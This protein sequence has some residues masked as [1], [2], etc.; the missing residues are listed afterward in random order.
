[1]ETSITADTSK[2]RVRE[3][4]EVL[5]EEA[6][7]HKVIGAF[8]HVYNTLGYGFLEAVYA[9]ALEVELAHRGLHVAREIS[10]N[11]WYANEIV[12]QYR[13]DLLVE[14][15]VVVELKAHR[16]LVPQDR[17]QLLNCL[18]A[19]DLEAGLLLN[20]GLRPAFLRVV[21]SNET[22]PSRRHPRESPPVSASSACATNNAVAVPRSNS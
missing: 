9:R 5:L 6:L 7:T 20:F 8:F 15:V 1:M 19:S 17:A 3:C 18:R 14:N 21:S 2:R 4:H 22:A 13:A 10:I 16:V 11:V 12:G